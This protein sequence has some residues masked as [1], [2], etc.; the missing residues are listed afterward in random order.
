MLISDI[1]SAMDEWAPPCLAEEWDNVGLIVGDKNDVLRGIVAALDADA[2]ALRL[3]SDTGA[4][5]VIAHHPLIFRPAARITED[6]PTGRL[7][8]YAARHGISVFAAH[9]NLDRAHGGVND[10]L[11]GK[12]GL[13]PEAVPD[14]PPCWRIAS[15]PEGT[16]FSS[17][18]ESVKNAFPAGIETVRTNETCGKVFV[19]SGSGADYIRDA[20]ALGADTFVTG[21]MTYHN[22]QLA[23]ALGMGVILLGHDGSEAHIVAGISDY[24]QNRVSGLQ[25]NRIKITVAVKRSVQSVRL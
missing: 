6:D 25:S 19:C 14:D 24:L 7:V 22:R 10:L 23:A 21:E 18:A 8:L 17:F 5:M 4:N 15:L 1:I 2:E 9:T 16:A 3:A 20:H 12:L 13:V 11:C